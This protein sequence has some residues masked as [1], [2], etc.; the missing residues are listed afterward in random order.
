MC[1]I[2]L[3]KYDKDF[4][5]LRALRAA[6]SLF[7]MPLRKRCKGLFIGL[8]F[9]LLKENTRG[10]NTT[11]SYWSFF[12]LFKG[13]LRKIKKILESRFICLKEFNI[14]FSTKGIEAFYFCFFRVHTSIDLPVESIFFS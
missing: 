5:S 7:F 9:L 14:K 6:P 8:Y 2:S 4:M 1:N 13:S 12:T 10:F 3:L 11:V